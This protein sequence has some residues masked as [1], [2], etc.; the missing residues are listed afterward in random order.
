MPSCTIAECAPEERGPEDLV[1]AGG[2][3]EKIDKNEVLAFCSGME[4]GGVTIDVEKGMEI[5]RN[6]SLDEALVL[7]GRLSPQARIAQQIYEGLKELQR[8]NVAAFFTEQQIALPLDQFLVAETQAGST[9]LHLA[10][11]SPSVV[12]AIDLLL[13][14]PYAATMSAGNH[15]DHFTPLHYAAYYCRAENLRALL[16]GKD[17]HE[18]LNARDKDGTTPLDWAMRCQAE[19]S[20]W[21]KDA[22]GKCA[23]C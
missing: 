8:N 3:A 7:L 21:L 6:F 23:T 5:I 2:G 16:K 17:I 13:R 14:T 12:Q 22:G 11:W 9:V 19:P 1:S 20:H 18:V 4:V 10:A 15:V